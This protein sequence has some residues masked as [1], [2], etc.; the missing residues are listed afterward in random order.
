MAGH[1]RRAQRAIG[2]N[3]P[4][5]DRSVRPS[6]SDWQ[7]GNLQLRRFCMSSLNSSPARAAIF[8]TQQGESLL[9]PS[10]G[11]KQVSASVFLGT[12]SSSSPSSLSSNL[13]K[14]GIRRKVPPR[15][16]L[17]WG[18]SLLFSVTSASKL[19]M[20]KGPTNHR[21]ER[22]KGNDAANQPNGTSPLGR[23]PW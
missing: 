19:R 3:Y 4:T 11:R 22:E 5:D 17:F 7:F 8:G 2:H 15:L 13:H 1:S 12:T 10:V 6:S 23:Q 21:R 9:R 14:S 18:R 16:G 20:T